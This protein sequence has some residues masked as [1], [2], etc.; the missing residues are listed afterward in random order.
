MRFARSDR[1]GAM[2]ALVAIVA[3]C[4]AC[5]TRL[6]DLELVP[7]DRAFSSVEERAIRDIAESTA[8]DVRALIPTLPKRITLVVQTGKQHVIPET[9][10]TGTIAQPSSVYWTVDPDRDVLSII[11]KE[12]R[13]TLF[14]ELHHLAR[15]ARVARVAL[16]DSVVTE[17]LATAFERDFG[18]VHPPWGEPPPEIEQWTREVMAEPPTAPREKWLSR[19]P[20]GRRWIGLRVGTFLVDRAMKTSGRTSAELVSV[21]TAE[22]LQ[23]AKFGEK[24]D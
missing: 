7:E 14:H 5:E 18:G 22:I 6:V 17:G 10:E 8:R 3:P 2:S 16:L 24:H 20:D 19:H 11:R 15:E 12:L 21:P 23:M 9:G 1:I 4:V 13:P